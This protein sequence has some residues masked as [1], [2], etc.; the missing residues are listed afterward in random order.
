[1]ITLHHL[2]DSRSQRILWMLEELGVEYEIHY[3][4]RDPET[5]LAPPELKAVHPLGKSPV[6]VDG[7]RTF[8]E[9]AVILEYLARTYG[10]GD[11]A[12]EFGDPGYWTFQYW[13]HYGEA[14]LMPP[15]LLKLVF[16][17]LRQPPVPLLI[18]PISSKIAD[19]VDRAFTDPQIATHF[20]YVDGFLTDHEWFGGSS[21]SAADV[22][23]SF[24]LEA[25]RMRAVKAGQY[26]QID[27]WLKRVH[28]RPAYLRALEAGGEYAYGPDVDD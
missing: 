8:A 3:Y 13:M 18:R 7:D 10:G 11:W 6:I 1:M 28:A 19:Q 16:S 24:P 27:A 14:S 21:I 12:P 5:N 22:Q 15:L 9:S 2:E 20:E 17:K 4:E 26:P 23:M 25:A